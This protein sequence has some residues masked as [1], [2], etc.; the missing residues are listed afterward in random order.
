MVKKRIHA[1]QQSALS[2]HFTN[3][4]TVRSQEGKTSWA[5]VCPSTTYVLTS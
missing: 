3:A 4:Y 5:T 2:R 1:D